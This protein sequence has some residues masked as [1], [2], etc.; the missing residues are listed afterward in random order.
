MLKI[1]NTLFALT[2][3]L[4]STAAIGSNSLSTTETEDIQADI[5]G[6]EYAWSTFK[7][8][9]PIIYT[10]N[11]CVQRKDYL[12]RK[13]LALSNDDSYTTY[14][15]DNFSVL[16]QTISETYKLLEGCSNYLKYTR[17]GRLIENKQLATKLTMT[18]GMMYAFHDGFVRGMI[19]ENPSKEA[20]AL[21]LAYI[22]LNDDIQTL[23]DLLQ[24]NSLIKEEEPS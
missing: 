20:Q 2:L 21:E 11:Y 24:K 12:F 17:Q 14:S 8:T 7:M 23:A 9:F 22:Q 6:R 15:E 13:I 4:L 3:S 19:R 16:G 5:E 18:V 10:H 1:P